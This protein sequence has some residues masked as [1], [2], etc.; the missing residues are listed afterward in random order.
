VS[1]TT[2][3]LPS[4][5]TTAQPTTTT[6]AMPT[7]TPTIATTTT[8]DQLSRDVETVVA[9]YEEWNQ[10][11]RSGRQAIEAFLNAHLYPGLPK[12]ASGQPVPFA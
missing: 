4:T 11:V 2:T 6:T 8:L 9:F 7:T 1:S 12:C 10:A 5:T 3:A